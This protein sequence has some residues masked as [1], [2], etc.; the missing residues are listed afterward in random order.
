[1]ADDEQARP[2]IMRPRPTVELTEAECWQL[3]ASA[4]LGRVVFTQH[5]LPAIRPVNHLVDDRAII[6]RSHLRSAITARAADQEGN[7]V[8]VCYEADDINVARHTGW[9]V[10]ATGWARLVSDP[11]LVT[12]YER[13][14]EPWVDRPM[15]YV[16]AIRPQIITGIRLVGWCC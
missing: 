8:V 4:P 14:L 15:D 7:G 11:A 5:A 1:V 10:I 9:S 16:I 13:E 12:R 6:I 3:L 2:Q